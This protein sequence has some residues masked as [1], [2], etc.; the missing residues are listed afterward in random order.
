VV[1]RDDTC[2]QLT[3]TAKWKSIKELTGSQSCRH[4]CRAAAGCTAYTF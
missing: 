1:I 4:K 2:W 3:D